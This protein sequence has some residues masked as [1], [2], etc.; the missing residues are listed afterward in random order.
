MRIIGIDP[1]SLATG[2]GIVEASG[3]RPSHVASGRILS[4]ASLAFNWRLENIFRELTAIIGEHA[5]QVMAVEDLFYAR[6]VKTALKLG[7]VRGVVI[8]AGIK[9]G[10]NIAEYSPLEVKQALVGYGRA[11]KKQVQIMVQNLL[12]LEGLPQADTADALAVAIC[13]LHSCQVTS[14]IARGM[15]S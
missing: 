9:A 13:H 11:Q 1:G 2:Y 5:P 12:S 6:N 15:T 14:R 7:H 8:L 4:P 3:R 10:L